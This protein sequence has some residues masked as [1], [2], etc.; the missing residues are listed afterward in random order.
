MSFF[1]LLSGSVNIYALPIDIFG[2]E[3]AGITISALTFAFGVMQM[4]LSPAIGYMGEHRLYTQVGWFVA[5]PP[6]LAALVL[7]AVQ[8]QNRK[9]LTLEPSLS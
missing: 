2:A 4:I 3:R 7:L 6:V 9:R 1:F 8:D 5:I